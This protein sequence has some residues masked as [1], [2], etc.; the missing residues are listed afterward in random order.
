MGNI[1]YHAHPATRGEAVFGLVN[2]KVSS[3]WM[4]WDFYIT[5]GERKAVRIYPN[6]KNIGTLTMLQHDQQI[7]QL[8]IHAKQRRGEGI[9]FNQLR[10]YRIGD[11]LSQIDWKATSRQVKLISREY[12]DERD[13]DIIFLLDCGRRMRAMDGEFSHFD[14]ALNAMLLT[15]Y[16]ALKQGDSVGVLPFAGQDRWLAPIKGPKAI[17]KL[18]N[19]VYDLHNTTKT[20]DFLQ[21]AER[22][23]THHRKRALVILISNV[24]EEDKGDLLAASRMLAKHHLVMVASLRENI[25]DYLSSTPVD[26]FQAALNYAGAMHLLENR[27]KVLDSVVGSGVIL[28]DSL[29]RNLHVDLVNQYLTLKRN[30]RL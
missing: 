13:Q 15:S 14:H 6:F 1:L 21:A 18:L 28:T 29:A 17:N 7:N 20:S 19:N 2:L 30:G 12:Q 10:E 8:G 5:S 4:F 16:I 25:L 3:R 26:S 22:L 27:K 24:Q 23:V 9:N 11:S